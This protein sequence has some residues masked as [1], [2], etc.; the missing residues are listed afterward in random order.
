MKAVWLFLTNFGNY[1]E[2][3]LLHFSGYKIVA[4]VGP[5]SRGGDINHIYIHER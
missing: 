4:E 3:F 2:A 5:V 1:E